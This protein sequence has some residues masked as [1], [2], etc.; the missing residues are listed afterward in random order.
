MICDACVDL[1]IDLLT[2]D[3]PHPLP[4]ARIHRER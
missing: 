4:V 1:C 3:A 2:E